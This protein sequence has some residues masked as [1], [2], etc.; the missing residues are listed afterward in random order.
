MCAWAVLRSSTPP[1]CLSV[2]RLAPFCR[3]AAP[4]HR[5]VCLCAKSDTH[6]HTLLGVLFR[7]TQRLE[8]N[9]FLIGNSTDQYFKKMALNPS[10]RQGDMGHFSPGGATHYLGVGTNCETTAPT[11]WQWTAPGFPISKFTALSFD[12]SSWTD[13]SN[14]QLW[15][16]FFVLSYQSILVKSL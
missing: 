2:P 8:Y 13:P 11:F 7:Y 10:N 5:V 3:S 15:I 4:C 16:N 12:R 6:I 9:R 14:H 1:P